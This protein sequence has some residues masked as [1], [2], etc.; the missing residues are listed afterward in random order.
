MV[1]MTRD[2]GAGDA[3]VMGDLLEGQSMKKSREE[4]RAGVSN[5]CKMTVV[6]SVFAA[7]V[8]SGVLGVNHSAWATVGGEVIWSSLDPQLGKQEAAASVVDSAGNFIITGASTGLGGNENWYTIKLD[9]SGTV[10]WQK[11]FDFGRDGFEPDEGSENDRALAVA[12]DSGNNIIVAGYGS[13]N[14]NVD[15]I[16]MKYD[17]T[18]NV[19]WG[20]YA[21]NGSGNGYD[22]PSSLAID[23]DDNIYVA[24]YC[25]TA[26]NTDDGVLL[27]L[28]ADGTLIRAVTYN[29]DAVANEDDR[30]VDVTTGND[31]PGI[32][33]DDYVVVTG[34]SWHDHSGRPDFDYVTVKYNAGGVEQWVATFD[35]GDNDDRGQFVKV[36]ANHDVVV[37]GYRTVGTRKDIHTIKYD[38]YADLSGKAVVLWEQTH[39]DTAVYDQNL[40]QALMLDATGDVYIAGAIFTDIGMD[41][42]YVTRRQGS[43]GTQ[44]WKTIYDSDGKEQKDIP[45]ALA[46]DT[47]GGVFVSGYVQ[48]GNTALLDFLTVKFHQESGDVLWQDVHDGPSGGNQQA[49]GMAVGMS[50]V[51]DGNVY[52][53]G[54]SGVRTDYAI[55]VATNSSADKL[56]VI[57][58][59]QTPWAVDQ[60]KSYYVLMTSGANAGENKR[61][62]SNTDHVLTVQSTFSSQV[63]AGSSYVINNPN[64]YDFYAVKYDYGM[65]NPPTRVTTTVVSETEV[66]LDWIDRSTTVDEDDFCV[67][68]CSGIGCGGADFVEIACRTSAELPFVDA[69]LTPHVRYT[70]RVRSRKLPDYSGYSEPIGVLST[71]YAP[72]APD[73]VYSYNGPD[74]LA[75][76]AM[77]IAVGPDNDPVVTGTSISSGGQFDYYTAKINRD[78]AATRWAHRYNDPDGETDVATCVSVMES[79]EV[80]VSGYSSL[81]SSG[82]TVNTNDIFTLH[83]SSSG[84]DIYNLVPPDYG[85]MWTDQYNGPS[86]GDDRSEAV[87]TTSNGTATAVVG[88]GRNAQYNDDIYV[89]YYDASGTRV[90]SDSYDGG[91]GSDYPRAVVIDDAGNVIVGGTTFNGITYDHFLRKYGADGSIVWTKIYDSTYG[92][93]ELNDLATDPSGNI[94]G[95]GYITNEADHLDM[96][97]RQ[98]NSAGSDQWTELIGGDGIGYDEA[99]AVAY[100]PLRDEVVVAG[101][102]TSETGSIDYQVRRHLAGSGGKVWAQ[103]LDHQVAD[104]FLVAMAMDADGNVCVA[105]DTDNGANTDILSV[106]YDAVGNLIGST[107]YNGAGGG[108]DFTSAMA[109]NSLGEMFVAG[110]T[111]NDVG[112]FDYLVFKSD[113]HTLL[114]PGLLSADPRYTTVD[115]HWTDN[116]VGEESYEIWRKDSDCATGGNYA[117]IH[118]SA[119]DADNFTDVGLSESSS[120]CYRVQTFKGGITSVPVEIDVRTTT[121]TAPGCSAVAVS[122]TELALT[123]VD[124]T[125]GEEGVDLLRCLGADCQISAPGDTLVSFGAG[126]VAY[127]DASVCQSGQYTYR[128][129]FYN[130][131][132]NWQ[133][134]SDCSNVAPFPVV[135]LDHV[136]A[137]AVSEGEVIV[138]WLD[139]NPDAEGYSI[140]KCQGVGC[141]PAAP[142]LTAAGL[143][144]FSPVVDLKF[145]DGIW[146]DAS[147]NNN[148]AIAKNGATFANPG[149]MGGGAADFD[150][151]DDLAEWTYTSGW[152]TNNFTMAAWFK[153]DPGVTHEIDPQSTSSTTGTSGQHYLFGAQ[154]RTS[155]QAGAGVSV[156]TN[157][158]SVYEHAGGYMPPLAVYNAPISSGWNHLVVTYTDRRPN[159]YLNG[160]LV[161]GGYTSPKT[162][163]FAPYQVGGGAYGN[164]PGQVDEV[165]IFNYALSAQEVAALSQTGF[166]SDKNVLPGESYTYRVTATKSTGC[167]WESGPAEATVVPDLSTPCPLS[168]LPVNTTS[169]DL[170][171][172]D[173]FS[174]ETGYEIERCEGAGC[175]DS[176][177]AGSSCTVGTAAASATHFNDH[178][179]LCPGTAYNYQVRAYKGAYLWSSVCTG[180]A[181]LPT[182]TVPTNLSAARY[183]EQEISLTWDDA[184]GDETGFSLER[185]EVGVSCP[186]FSVIGSAP[187]ASGQGSYLDKGPGG[188]GLEVGHT[189]RYRV[190]AVKAS[191]C[192]WPTGYSNESN[193]ATPTMIG[194]SALK[195]AVINSTDVRLRWVNGTTWESSFSIGRCEV[196]VDCPTFSEIAAIG[197]GSTTY[198]DKSVCPGGIYQ[199]QVT[200]VNTAWPQPYP[201]AGPS[202]A[203]TTSRVQ[204]PYGLQLSAV[205]ES[206]VDVSW[207]DTNPDERSFSVERCVGNEASCLAGPY[208]PVG[209]VA[210]NTPKLASAPTDY[211]LHYQ[212]DESSWPSTASDVQDSS[213]NG[214]HATSLSTPGKV[215]SSVSGRAGNLDGYTDYI[216][217]DNSYTLSRF[218]STLSWWMKPDSTVNMGLFN[219]SSYNSTTSLIESRSTQLY[220]ETNNNCNYITFPGVTKN[221]DWTMYTIVFDNER[222]YLYV[223]GSFFGETPD[224]GTD[225]CSTTKATKLLADLSLRYLG[226]SSGYTSKFFDGQ[227]DELAI[228]SR[229]LSAEEIATRYESLAMKFLLHFEEDNWNGSTGEVYDV[230]AHGHHGTTHGDVSMAGKNEHQRAAYFDGSGDYI[231]LGDIDEL[232]A[233][234]ALSVSL[235][236]NRSADQAAAT[237]HGIDNVLI[238]QSDDADNDNLEIGTQGGAVEIYLDTASGADPVKSVDVGIQN[239][240]WY[241]LVLTYDSKVSNPLKLYIDGIL[242]GQWSEF[243]GALASSGISPLT[244]GMARPG[245][246]QFPGGDFNGY[247]DEVGAYGYAL[248]AAQVDALYQG[249]FQDSGLLSL[250]P[251]TYRVTAEKSASCSWPP[252]YSAPVEITTPAP[253]PPTDLVAIPVNTTRIDLAWTDTTGSET[254]YKILRCLDSGGGCTPTEIAQVPAN[255]QSYRDTTLCTPGTYFY[256]VAAVVSGVD[257][258]NQPGAVSAVPLLPVAPTGLS[259]NTPNE[260]QALLN[261]TDQMTEE[262]GYK[263]ERCAGA[264]CISSSSDI[265]GESVHPVVEDFSTGINPALWNQNGSSVQAGSTTPPIDISDSYGSVTISEVNGSVEMETTSTGL[266][267]SGWPYN[268]AG[269]TRVNPAFLGSGDFNVEIDYALPDGDLSASYTEATIQ[270]R[271]IIYMGADYFYVDRGHNNGASYYQGA[272]R[273]DGTNSSGYFTTTDTVGKLRLARIG[274]TLNCYAWISGSWHLLHTRTMVSGTTP[275]SLS[276]YQ[277]AE[278]NEAVSVRTI[279]DN[280]TYSIYPSSSGEAYS[281]DDQTLVPDTTYAYKVYPFKDT[282]GWEG[283]AQSVEVTPQVTCP[284][285]LHEISY[286]TTEVALGWTDTTLAETAFE[287]ERCDG[288]CDGTGTFTK[289][290]ENAANQNAYTDQ[291]AHYS[292]PYSYRVNVSNS[293]QGWSCYSNITSATML[294]PVVPTTVQAE[295][296][297]EVRIDLSWDDTNVDESK[298]IIERGDAACENF[299]YLAEV[300]ADQVTF[301][302]TTVLHSTTYCYQVKACKNDLDPDPDPVL[303]DNGWC[304]LFGGPTTATTSI[305]PPQP[306]SAVAINTTKVDL[307]WNDNAESE[308]GFVLERCLGSGCT[309]FT[310]IGASPA[311]VNS[312]AAADAGVCAGKTYRYR[313]MSEKGTEWSSAFTDPPV[314]VTTPA[315][316]KVEAFRAEEVVNELDGRQVTLRW[317]DLNLDEDGFNLERCEGEGCTDYTPLATLT[318]LEDIKDGVDPVFWGQWGGVPTASST[319]LPIDVSDPTGVVQISEVTEGLEFVVTSVGGSSTWSSSALFMQHPDDLGTGDFDLQVDFD[320]PDGEIVPLTVNQFYLSLTVVFPDPDGSDPLVGDS[321]VLSRIANPTSGGKYKLVTKVNNIINSGT[322]LTTDTTG[323][324]RLVRLN[325]VVSAY[326]WTGGSWQQVG[327]SSP[328]LTSGLAPSQVSTGPAV[329]NTDPAVLRTVVRDVRISSIYADDTVAASTS[330]CYRISPTK[331]AACAWDPA[332]DKD[333]LYS[334]ICTVTAPAAPSNLT[335]TVDGMAITLHWQDNSLDEDGFEV[336]KKLDNGRYIVLGTVGPDLSTYTDARAINLNAFYTYRVRAVRSEDR[337]AYVE[338][339]TTE[340][341]FWQDPICTQ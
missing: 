272:I 133:T 246:S 150:G 99:V 223:N 120:Y 241:H 206:E 306:V 96:F 180:S 282:C 158:I 318:S 338:K 195:G 274:E 12:V 253:P 45:R 119:A 28:E 79:N 57:D 296:G 256:R 107:V 83:F 4:N 228:Y 132:E 143:D 80:V 75:D 327:P 183:S 217:L 8:L 103:T 316:Q 324:L 199:Y 26:S 286:N 331:A 46:I 221:T 161:R 86:S 317:S 121:P 268:Q 53:A 157:G 172:T 110:S 114:A 73:W 37:T 314:E 127:N 170:D 105:G 179:N 56:T 271:I 104:D 173:N 312:T 260:A 47:H 139:G 125:M 106:C 167:S 239:D 182:P 34:Y 176:C 30:F 137:A 215:A 224:Y 85:A 44:L 196:G 72:V 92:D 277:Y 82:G 1:T 214:R 308:T 189:Y 108:D 60:W 63:Q 235:W 24:G 313:V 185:C 285:D 11:E 177:A 58:N 59:A 242:R 144:P 102:Y 191:D 68:R 227:L 74:N 61:I 52:V 42:L 67:E 171:W 333:D 247:L 14:A 64:D 301:S 204:A 29:A 225:K 91:H 254:A 193:D 130:D 240:T 198:I 3:R 237:G 39:S 112:N 163:V 190:Q 337:S 280:F 251:Y 84:P 188:N 259:V 155:P 325:D 261:W 281:F 213:G 184:N 81:Y 113:T 10:L 276:L 69:G 129:R 49:V 326:A 322:M 174:F 166:Y 208:V 9:G 118:S 339:T 328:P 216:R 181:V 203:I 5:V 135:P 122:T 311:G 141:T 31:T 160:T 98:Y 252:T 336:L 245:G 128:V 332:L 149:F 231:A 43:D 138:S 334:E 297:S 305:L 295:R 243:S 219:L 152:P 321:I 207:L 169:V 154:L 222:S 41:D 51:A 238:S 287:V 258:E 244:L 249:V 94:Y 168:L 55:G 303:G 284:T 116:A 197:K 17:P 162:T 66:D 290:G 210:P 294:T 2:R 134:T 300:P 111:T 257:I 126:A 220:G 15:I 278:R 265:V 288:I 291:T 95:V 164:F 255:S 123:W 21:Y 209:I 109:V 299:A 304:T 266:G 145:N 283:Y 159:I 16:V 97:V 319:T 267:S 7:L 71:I 70:Y 320:L 234:V 309:G 262:Y 270:L 18:G 307:G 298:T 275:T 273:V 151:V 142:A 201:I 263:I 25:E 88:Y 175:L 62:V 140:Y 205:S 233:P 335:A 48:D 153:I 264:G 330:Y 13:V 50:V 341:T 101:M 187:A 178:N 226:N 315:A 279:V 35:G 192:G 23:S 323:T 27:K 100:D 194:P 248:T 131:A 136:S 54:W 230:S 293:G 124:T 40:P 6:C 269:L 117:H 76:T 292:A 90:W 165:K 19:L 33:G 310:E 36:D 78:S 22:Y 202:E 148:N 186:T 211:A 93:D 236:F 156:G 89:I 20:P 329:N 302:D 289:I 229:A 38:G 340:P 115:L 65:L 200:A 146:V 32:V 218:G 232:D 147:G 250:T 77:A 87:D 212:M